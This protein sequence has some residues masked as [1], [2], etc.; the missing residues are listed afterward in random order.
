MIDYACPVWRYTAL[1][2]IKKLRVLKTNCFRI[3]S[4]ALWYL[5]NRQIQISQRVE[6][7]LL[8]FRNKLFDQFGRH[9]C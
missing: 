4:N 7:K 6:S 5:G 9:L 3:A 8:D 2:H 1:S